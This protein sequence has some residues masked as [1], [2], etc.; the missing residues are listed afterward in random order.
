MAQAPGISNKLTLA[1]MR[2]AA[3]LRRG[4]QVTLLPANY[5]RG[6]RAPVPVSLL[7]APQD[8]RTADATVAEEIYSGYFAFGSKA[9]NAHG[10]S[11]FT[12]DPPSP[13]WQVALMNFGWLRDLRAANTPLA[14]ANASALVD[15]WIKLRG[16]KSG[17]MAWH[18]AVAARRLLSWLSH[19]PLVLENADIRFYR[20]FMKSIGRHVFFLQRQL[21]G[22]LQGEHR[23]LAAVALMQAALCAEGLPNLGKRATRWLIGEIN[24][25]ITID[26]A[27]ISRNP[28]V[29]SDMLLDF[30]PLRQAFVARN[31]TPPPEL[32]QAI[33]RMMPML[34]LF[35]HGD[36]ALALF[37]G[38]GVT[39]QESLL[40]GFVYDDAMAR[41]IMHA[42]ASGYQRI[43]AGELVLIADVGK[44]PPTHHSG[45]AHAG[46]LSFELSSCNFRIIVNCGATASHSGP[47]REAA[48]TTAAHST[49]VLADTSSS[50]FAGDEG[51]DRLLMGK[52]VAGPKHVTTERFE[53]ENG[54]TLQGSHDGY[55]R[56]FGVIHERAIAV[57]VDGNA[58]SGRDRLTPHA[59]HAGSQEPMEF[60]IRFHL[61]PQIKSGIID[62]GAGVLLLTPD[63]QQWVFRAGGL[64]IDLAESIFFANPD[65]AKATQQMVIAGEAPPGAE[66]DW[67]FERQFSE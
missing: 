47:S 19:S 66:I 52:V 20:R 30:L 7:I 26:G 53:S 39:R 28:Q 40:T 56:T 17:T 12:I 23:L 10:K 54:V 5:L 16:T 48:R 67:T 21:S 46:T 4:W 22:G 35:R 2:T 24:R 1:R 62:N 64:T 31:L 33:D 8:I 6:L 32:V 41:P 9:V 14:K 49:L 59:K 36:G 61:H 51:I 29:L 55:A 15:E 37:N 27:H 50:H 25:Q 63:D 11:P 42:I 65:G 44:P 3:G 58:L 13:E 57:S 45:N 18:P 38:M 43:E 60:A 34:R